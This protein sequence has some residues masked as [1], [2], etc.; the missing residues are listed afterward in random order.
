MRFVSGKAGALCL[1][2][3]LAA[4]ATGPVG[5]AMAQQADQ[6]VPNIVVNGARPAD[7]VPTGL[8][9][10][11]GSGDTAPVPGTQYL[12]RRDAREFRDRISSGTAFPETQY[13]T[14][15]LHPSASPHA[16]VSPQGA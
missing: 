8:A 2:A 16:T 15:P 11:S 13:L 14:R 7:P 12:T 4:M 6:R 3:M 9:T 1:L 5:S 10:L